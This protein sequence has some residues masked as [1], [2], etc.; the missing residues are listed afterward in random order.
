MC[1]PINTSIYSHKLV[2]RTREWGK[3]DA[4]KP[5]RDTGFH[6]QA[7]WNKLVLNCVGVG[8]GDRGADSHREDGRSG[9]VLESRT[10]PFSDPLDTPVKRPSAYPWRT[11]SFPAREI[12]FPCF[13]DPHYASYTK[14][15][16]THN[17][18]SDTLEKVEFTFGL[19]M[20]TFFCDP[21]GLF[22]NLLEI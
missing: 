11:A 5:L 7:S 1:Y 19:Y 6:D 14:A 18:T 17:L 12:Q 3:L 20:R 21:S 13:L 9:M 4:E 10:E 22:F 15:A 8:T 16:L 2:G